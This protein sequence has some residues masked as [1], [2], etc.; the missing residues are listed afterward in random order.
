M[1]RLGLNCSI[2]QRFIFMNL[3]FELVMQFISFRRIKLQKTKYLTQYV[4]FF[5]RD[6]PNPSEQSLQNIL[7]LT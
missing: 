4:D 2:S 7:L 1:I 5:L 3:I 6:S